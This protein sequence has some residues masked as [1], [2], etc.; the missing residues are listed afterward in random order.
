M[1]HYNMPPFQLLHRIQIIH[2]LQICRIMNLIAI[3]LKKGH[4]MFFKLLQKTA[5]CCKD[6]YFLHTLPSVTPQ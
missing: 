5:Y 2:I 1:M 3:S 6:Q 4:M